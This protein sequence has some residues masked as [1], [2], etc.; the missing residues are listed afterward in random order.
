M[1][2]LDVM[3]ALEVI[4]G[5]LPYT[6]DHDEEG[7]F[8]F[9]REDDAAAMLGDVLAALIV[10]GLC[11]TLPDDSPV[12]E[13]HLNDAIRSFETARRELDTVIGT[14]ED[15]RRAVK[16]SAPPEMAERES[17]LERPDPTKAGRLRRVTNTRSRT[18]RGHLASRSDS[19]L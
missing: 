4:F 8:A 6:A 19:L 12:M 9:L 7:N 13:E 5:P 2:A 15:L 17:P 1:N 3:E 10:R 11:R 16:S 14:L 18:R